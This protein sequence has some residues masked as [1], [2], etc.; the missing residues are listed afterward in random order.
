MI[1]VKKYNTIWKFPIKL[2]RNKD[3]ENGS[4]RRITIIF[5]NRRKQFSQC[6]IQGFL[7]SRPFQ[8]EDSGLKRNNFPGTFSVES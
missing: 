5:P 8:I 7:S 2:L 4:T 3:H 1:H 6:E